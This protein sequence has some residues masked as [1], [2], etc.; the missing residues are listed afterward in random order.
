[1]SK[2]TFLSL[3]IILLSF[4]LAPNA[5]QGGI[6]LSDLFAGESIDSGSVIY[7]NFQLLADDGTIA[8]DLASASVCAQVTD[9][10]SSLKFDFGTGLTLDPGFDSVVF[11]LGYD[12]TARGGLINGETLQIGST[13]SAGVEGLIDV[14]SDLSLGTTLLSSQSA[15]ID[16]IFGVDE[17]ISFSVIPPTQ[18]FAAQTS[19]S[20]FADENF[21]APDFV[22]LDSFTQSFS[23]SAVPE[24]SSFVTLASALGLVTLRRRRRS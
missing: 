20:V 21:T 22:T 18:T 17:R 15:T 1:M 9:G 16:P 10:V 3:A 24:P 8:L 12:V 2:S 19:F 23:V 14:A 13:S 11:Q 6:A 4:G 5:S 7:D